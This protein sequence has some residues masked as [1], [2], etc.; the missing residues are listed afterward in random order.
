VKAITWILGILSVI[1]LGITLINLICDESYSLLMYDIKNKFADNM[2]YVVFF[3]LL[4]FIVV[5]GGGVYWRILCG[6][7][8]VSW[9]SKIKNKLYRTALRRRMP[10]LKLVTDIVCIVV[11]AICLYI[12]SCIFY[13][14]L[15]QGTWEQTKTIGHSFGAVNGD[16]YTGSLEAFEYNYALGR[17]TMEVDL[18]L[19]T[20]NQLVL[21]HD[22]DTPAQDGISERV[23]PDK[24]TFLNT[25]LLGKYTPLSFNQLCEIMTE[26][27]DIWIVTDTKSTENEEIRKQFEVMIDT[28]QQ[29]NCEEILDRIIVQVYNE[30]MYEIVKSIYDF[31]NYI[32]TMYWRFYNDDWL[33]IT[34]DVCRFCVNHGIETIAIGTNRI[35]PEMK[36]IAD[37][38][39]RN[40]YIHTVNDMEEANNYFEMGVNGIYTD[41]ITDRDL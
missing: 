13:R 40:V 15:P 9:F 37:H 5:W 41:I 1:V 21:K 8:S 4:I 30:E 2:V 25:M 18:I 20:D 6:S 7:I 27:P 24:E 12:N 34:R 10:D 23:P 33:G 38:Y 17:R 39:E 32:F 22:W 28:V 3:V 36:A 16:D 29:L 26:Y 19:T 31:N 35:S 14:D 11:I